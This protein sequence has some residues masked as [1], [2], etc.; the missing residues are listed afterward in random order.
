MYVL[1]N[2][3]IF[4]NN[5][6]PGGK[7]ENTSQ[8]ANTIRCSNSVI[9]VGVCDADDDWLLFCD[10]LPLLLFDIGRLNGTAIFDE[11]F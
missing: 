2:D 10:E 5:L 7:L 8:S 11:S 9:C 6:V 4:I 1:I 3:L